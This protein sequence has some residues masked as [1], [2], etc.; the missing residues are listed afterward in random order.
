MLF[1]NAEGT[2]IDCIKGDIVV[3]N[4]GWNKDPGSE[5]ADKDEGVN[6]EGVRPIAVSDIFEL[7]KMSIFPKL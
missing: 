2:L 5:N 7:S 1:E 3:M 4:G 6:G